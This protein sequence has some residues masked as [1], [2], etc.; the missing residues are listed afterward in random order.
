MGR[1]FNHKTDRLSQVFRLKHL[2]TLVLRHRH[3]SAIQDLGGDFGRLN[4]ATSDPV[5]S[6]F[7]IERGTHG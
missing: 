2:L 6:F 7:K 3:R 5:T 4:A 1:H